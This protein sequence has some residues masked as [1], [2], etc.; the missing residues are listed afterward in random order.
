MNT[1]AA[2]SSMIFT[3]LAVIATIGLRMTFCRHKARYFTT[4]IKW[5]VSAALLSTMIHACTIDVA[6]GSFPGWSAYLKP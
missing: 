6:R 2:Y 1:I 5:L 3:L 4:A